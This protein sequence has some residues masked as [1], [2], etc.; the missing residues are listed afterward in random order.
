LPAAETATRLRLSGRP[1]RR[2]LSVGVRDRA[3]VLSVCWLR[4]A[5]QPVTFL[6]AD[7]QVRIVSE[8]ANL[9]IR[10]LRR[11]GIDGP[12]Y[13]YETTA[14]RV[15]V[16]LNS[17]ETI[18]LA[19]EGEALAL[20]RVLD[21]LRKQRS[22]RLRRPADAWRLRDLI[23]RDFEIEPVAYVLVARGGLIEPRRFVS[24]S[25]CYVSRDLLVTTSGEEWRVSAV[26]GDE[27]AVQTLLCHAEP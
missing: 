3:F 10:W 2:L 20:L 21:H 8:D 17:G 18:T 11:H 5:D 13:R 7:T 6:V 24:H 25:G 14:D 16:A 27:D 4:M 12:L 1:F 19:T 9:L 23:I 22:E 26:E 15:G